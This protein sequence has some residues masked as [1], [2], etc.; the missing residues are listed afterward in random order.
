MPRDRYGWSSRRRAQ[1]IPT[2][3]RS[4]VAGIRLP[5]FAA[6]R[7]EVDVTSITASTTS[8]VAPSVWKSDRHLHHPLAVDDAR[9]D[10]RCAP[11]T[12]KVRIGVPRSGLR[13]DSP[14]TGRQRTAPRRRRALWR[15]TRRRHKDSSRSL[16]PCTRSSGH[17]SDRSRL[18]RRGWARGLSNRKHR[19]AY[20]MTY[21]Q[22]QRRG[23]SAARHGAGPDIA[24]SSSG[25]RK[26]QEPLVLRQ[27]PPGITDGVTPSAGHVIPR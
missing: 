24:A 3:F 27:M 10:G 9:G 14:S 2:P 13:V 21:D 16:W 26:D 11:P 4:P 19:P 5:L 12:I 23:G 7:P 8:T 15:T 6:Y 1:R 22:S 25:Q 18:D 20:H 17:T